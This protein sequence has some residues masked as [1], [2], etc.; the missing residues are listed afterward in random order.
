MNGVELD[1]AAVEASL[2]ARILA[3]VDMSNDQ[4]SSTPVSMEESGDANQNYAMLKVQ[5]S[6]I[7]RAQG[8]SKRALKAKAKGQ[9]VPHVRFFPS[10]LYQ[11]WK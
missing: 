2:R 3:Y 6:E 4:D 10:L 1:D 9:A 11:T 5:M 8:A 7:Q